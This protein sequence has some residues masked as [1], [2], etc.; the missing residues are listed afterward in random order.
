LTNKVKSSTKK[1]NIDLRKEE[2]SG[3]FEEEITSAQVK[4]VTVITVDFNDLKNEAAKMKNLATEILSYKRK[5]EVC[6]QDK[7]KETT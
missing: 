7:K 6:Y 3:Q 1:E 2:T 4:E 5:F